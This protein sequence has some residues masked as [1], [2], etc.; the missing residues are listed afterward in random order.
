VSRIRTD[1]LPAVLLGL[2]VLAA[3]GSALSAEFVWDDGPLI[4]ENSLIRDA[5]GV[6]ELLTSSFWDTGDKYDRFRAFFRPLV[7]LS[8]AADYSIWGLRPFGFHLTNLLLHWGCCVWLFAVARQEQLERWP[9]FAAG[10]LFAVHPVH[11]ESVVWVSGRTDLVSAFFMLGAFVLARGP[12]GWSAPS[13]RLVS[14]VFFASSL[15][16]K[17]MAVM[18]PLLL[19]LDFWFRADGSRRAR[20]RRGVSGVM[21]YLAVLAVYGLLRQVVLGQAVEVAYRLDW[22]AHVASS[23]FVMARYVMLLLLPV[24]LDAHYPDQAIESFASPLFVVSVLIVFVLFFAAR[25]F[26]GTAPRV[27]SWILWMP[28]SILPVLAFGRFGDVLMADRYMYIPSVGLALLLGYACAWAVRGMDRRTVTAAATIVA[29]LLVL[30]TVGSRL[31]SRVWQNDLSLFSDM[32]RT[33]G[34]SALVQNNL[35]LAHYHQGSYATATRS[36]RRALEIAPDFALARNNLAAA[37]EREGKLVEALIEYEAALRDAPSMPE[38]RVNAAAAML[39][40]GRGQD[41]LAMMR[42]LVRE[43]PGNLE[44][45]FGLAQALQ[46]LGRSGEADAE[47]DRLLRIDPNFAKAYYL[48]GTMASERGEPRA[49]AAAMRSFLA[50]WAESDEFAA[51]ARRVVEEA[52]ELPE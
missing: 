52:S 45:R 22:V 46:L 49:S 13:R 38:A 28:L 35:G 33:S 24:G 23:F 5:D 44:G 40:V 7:A 47:L 15:L 16:A 10:A 37:Y 21:P 14:I 17:E 42:K 39:R 25:R 51:V 30:L 36:F 20:L 43:Q 48:R 50:L 12:D 3:L 26:A 9:A 6:R 4:V 11:V 8:Y 2:L 31:R 32:A 41:A 34:S 29:S 18:L 1:L 27:T 19:L